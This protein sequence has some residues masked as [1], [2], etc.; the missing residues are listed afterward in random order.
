MEGQD[1]W[2]GLWGPSAHKTLCLFTQ[3]AQVLSV[4]CRDAGVLST[5]GRLSEAIATALPSSPR[6]VQAGGSTENY[7]G[8]Q[9][10]N[11]NNSVAFSTL[12]ILYNHLSQ[13]IP[14]SQKETFS[15]PFALPWPLATPNLL[16]IHGLFWTFYIK[17]LCTQFPMSGGGSPHQPSSHIIWVP[18]NST[19]F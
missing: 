5:A 4:F 15:P 12:A 17:I 6:T 10:S 11:V 16:S 19:Q 3:A 13:N 9:H 14:S 2:I 7:Q 1:K 8:S 18:Y